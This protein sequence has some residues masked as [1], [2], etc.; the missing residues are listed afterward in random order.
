MFIDLDDC[1]PRMPH[2]WDV[3]LRKPIILYAERNTTLRLFM[4]DMFDLAG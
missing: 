2:L 4:S 1:H 3:P